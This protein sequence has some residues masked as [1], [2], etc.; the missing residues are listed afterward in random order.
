MRKIIVEKMV[1]EVGEVIDLEKAKPEL[2]CHGNKLSIMGKAKKAVVFRVKE[3]KGQGAKRNYYL[4]Y[5]IT[6]TGHN[7]Q[8]NDTEV[9][10]CEVVKN[11]NFAD[12]FI[13]EEE[14]EHE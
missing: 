2:K 12:F 3:C 1:L 6:D 7:I 9:G 14:Q 11:M 4:Y 13:K 5:C 10:E 8:L